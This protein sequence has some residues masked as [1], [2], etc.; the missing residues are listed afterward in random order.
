VKQLLRL[1]LSL[2][3]F[4]VYAGT[5]LDIAGLGGVHETPWFR[6][7]D[8]DETYRENSLGHLWQ[9]GLCCPSLLDPSLA[10]PGSH[11]VTMFA[12]MP[13]DKGCISPATGPSRPSA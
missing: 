5:T 11:I 7:W 4:A 13:Y 1:K 9:I 12:L 6:S 10:P 2:S 8:H 3:M